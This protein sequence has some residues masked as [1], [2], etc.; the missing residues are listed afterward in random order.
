MS[1]LNGC[2]TPAPAHPCTRSFPLGRA[3]RIDVRAS[4][5]ITARSV[6]RCSP[7]VLGIFAA[8]PIRVAAPPI[9]AKRMRAVLGE[10]LAIR[11]AVDLGQRLVL[12]HSLAG[13]GA[14]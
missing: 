1:R 5:W 9:H 13:C 2:I 8:V 3:H 12:I 14:S 4:V 11:D 6:W 10:E 7:H